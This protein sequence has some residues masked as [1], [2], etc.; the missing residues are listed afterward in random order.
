MVTLRN[1][2][3]HFV[4]KK[5]STEKML[6]RVAMGKYCMKADQHTKKLPPEGVHENTQFESGL[7]EVLQ[8]AYVVVRAN[9]LQGSAN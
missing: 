7:C 5:M 1:L 2:R 6:L 4:L 8:E 3:T 9:R